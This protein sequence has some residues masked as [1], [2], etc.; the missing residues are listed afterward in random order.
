MA[1]ILIVDDH[2]ALRLVIKAQL[3]QVLGVG[4]ILEADNGQTAIEAARQFEPDLAVLDLDIPRISG[5]DVIPRLKRIYPPIRILVIS[6][7]EQAIF[8]PRVRRAGAQGFVSKMQDMKEIVRCIE[9]V[10][11]GYTVFPEMRY[12][13]ELPLFNQLA[14][15]ERLALLSDKE[16]VILQMLVRGLSNKA[17]GELLFISNKTVSSHKTRIMGKLQATSLVDLVDLARRCRLTPAQ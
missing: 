7:Q 8:A 1:T 5:L 16:I 14:D 15:E 17:I 12:E 11:A 2:P 13:R 3:S 6:G 10:M 9:W 4:N